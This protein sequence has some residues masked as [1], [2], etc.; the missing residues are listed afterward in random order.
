MAEA[1]KIYAGVGA[2]GEP[3]MIKLSD[4]KVTEKIVSEIHSYLRDIAD[5]VNYGL[6]TGNWTPN[7]S[8]G[9]IDG[10]AVHVV[11]GAVDTPTE[12]YHDLG[13]V[14]KVYTVKRRSDYGIIKDAKSAEWTDKKI[15]LQSNTAN[16]EVILHLE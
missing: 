13:R 11:F 12:V 5:R 10:Q 7:E 14:P 8:T 4:G 1:K 3:P 2:I 15:W 9:S 6:S 16:L